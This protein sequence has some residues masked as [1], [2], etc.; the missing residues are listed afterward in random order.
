MC[1][2]VCACVDECFGYLL[3]FCVFN[4]QP[5]NSRVWPVTPVANSNHTLVC[6]HVTTNTPAS[7]VISSPL[8][9]PPIDPASAGA[10]AKQPPS[11]FAHSCI[12]PLACLSNQPLQQLKQSTSSAACTVSPHLQPPMADADGSFIVSQQSLD[13]LRALAATVG[14]LS[15]SVASI[16]QSIERF[17]PLPLPHVRYA[18]VCSQ[19]HARVT[20]R[21]EPGKDIWL[22]CRIPRARMTGPP[23]Q[24]ATPPSH[25]ANV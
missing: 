24:T 9:S 21:E 10:G 17:A 4:S 1:V 12:W 18:H 19:S 23:P 15:A 5:V 22:H 6:T 25:T 13:S 7:R 8:Q 16:N 14:E 11:P 20:E 3:I 2:C